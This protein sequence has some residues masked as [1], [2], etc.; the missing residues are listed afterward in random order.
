VT[1]VE[2]LVVLALIGTVASAVSLSL[3]PTARGTE[4]RS[5]AELLVARMRRASEETLLTGQPVALVWSERDYR[6]LALMEGSWVAHPSPLLGKAKTLD[7]GVLFQGE[8]LRGGFAVT[9][10]ALPASGSPLVLLIGTN[11]GDPARAVVVS[12][13]G[14]T[15]TV[16]EPGE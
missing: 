2:I 15:G 16:S 1:L 3:S 11:G 6:F 5:E 4:A 10:A 14:A 8:A 9:S 7:A 12:W 13:N